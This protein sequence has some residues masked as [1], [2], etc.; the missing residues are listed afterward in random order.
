M[1]LW[2]T[3]CDMKFSVPKDLILSDSHDDDGCDIAAG[4]S[5][6]DSSIGLTP[7]GIVQI[8]AVTIGAAAT[9]RNT[10]LMEL[11]V[12]S[13]PKFQS[14]GRE[15]LIELCVDLER[16]LEM[17][18]V[19]DWLDEYKKYACLLAMGIRDG[20]FLERGPETARDVLLF[21]LD[22][23][24]LRIREGKTVEDVSEAILD[25]IQD[26]DEPRLTQLVKDSFDR[27]KTP[28]D[29][30]DR[31]RQGQL[32]DLLELSREMATEADQIPLA[33]LAAAIEERVGCIITFVP[34]TIPGKARCPRAVRWRRKTAESWEHFVVY[35]PSSEGRD[36]MDPLTQ[37]AVAHEL[38]HVLLHHEPRGDDSDPREES[39]ANF[40]AAI[41]LL[42]LRGAPVKRVELS[43]ED[44]ESTLNL[45]RLTEDDRTLFRPQLE[46]AIAESTQG[47]SEESKQSRGAQEDSDYEARKTQARQELEIAITSPETRQ[48]VGKAMASAINC[49]LTAIP[50]ETD[51]YHPLPGSDSTARSVEKKA[52]STGA[53]SIDDIKRRMAELK[54]GGFSSPVRAE[55]PVLEEFLD[56]V[57][58]IIRGR[59]AATA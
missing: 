46:A 12:E 58:R 1:L 55:P 53:T 2:E 39:D 6:I 24:K 8:E 52:T 19:A 20:I 14:E 13:T 41:F 42:A 31:E 10:E 33:S 18:A 11:D 22:R 17:F 49:V 45:F 32:D 48:L 9:V 27:L 15:Q 56:P 37:A 59:A 36:S 3:V 54:I 5:A 7:S 35:E 50:S 29:A 47:A 23:P 34:A 30:A 4:T 25:A 26:G 38:A 57:E 16:L 44:V 21:L 28:E 51:A 40:L 43:F